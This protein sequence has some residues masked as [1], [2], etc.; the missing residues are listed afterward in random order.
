MDVVNTLNSVTYNQSIAETIVVAGL[1]IFV[2]GTALIMYWQ[3]LVMGA[4]GVVCLL[5]LMNHK[6]SGISVAQAQQSGI[7]ASSSHDTYMQD[8]MKSTEYNKEQCELA[9][10]DRGIEKEKPHDQ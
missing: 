4:I 10:K 2:I 5:V 6:D 3:Y 1:C 9:W 8:C 7:T